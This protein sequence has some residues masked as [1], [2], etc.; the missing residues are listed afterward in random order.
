MPFRWF[1]HK[2]QQN[3]IFSTPL[4]DDRQIQTNMYRD[5]L[6]RSLQYLIKNQ[7]LQYL[8]TFSK[9]SV[10]IYLLKLKS[11]CVLVQESEPAEGMIVNQVSRVTALFLLN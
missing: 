6:Y 11:F 5:K 7:T 10:P 9:A 2:M 3:Y 8:A 1:L 4:Q